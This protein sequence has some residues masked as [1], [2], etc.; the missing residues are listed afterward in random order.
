MAEVV[1]LLNSPLFEPD[2]TDRGGKCWAEV[3][4]E[5]PHGF[6]IFDATPELQLLLR[7]RKGGLAAVLVGSMCIMPN[8]FVA[9]VRATAGV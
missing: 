4:D 2:T 3:S 5:V 9:D 6:K 8:H 1:E 7:D